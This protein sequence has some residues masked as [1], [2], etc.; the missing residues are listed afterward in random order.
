M[1]GPNPYSSERWRKVRR[2]VLADQP[3]CVM[4]LKLNVTT[5]ANT[6]DH[7]EPHKGNED[8]FWSMD[9]LQ[10]LCASHHSGLKQSMERGGT[11]HDTACDEK[12]FPLDPGHPFNR[13]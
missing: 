12:G 1:K 8:L 11:G 10:A 6:V 7:I 13:R 5:P 4:C 2:M 3:L 9:N